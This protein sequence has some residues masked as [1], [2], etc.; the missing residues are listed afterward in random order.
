MQMVRDYTFTGLWAYLLLQMI[1][2]LYLMRGMTYAFDNNTGGNHPFRIQSTQGLSGTPYTATNLV[3]LLCCISLFLWMLPS[4][5]YYQ[6]TIHAAM[7]GQ[8]NIGGF[9]KWQELFLQVL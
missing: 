9:N 7:Q 8:I 3:E 2:P 4:T 1:L 5:L 6:C